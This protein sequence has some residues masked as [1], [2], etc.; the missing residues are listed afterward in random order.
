[1]QPIQNLRYVKH[2][3]I[4]LDKW[5]SV[6]CK[7]DNTLIYA[8]SYYLDIVSESWDAY[9]FG[10]YS[11]VMP[12]PIR[13]K[14]GITLLTQPAYCQQLGIF[15]KP[16]INIL[17]YFLDAI[18]TKFKFISLNFNSCNAILDILDNNIQVCNNYLL[19]LDANY[20]N[21]ALSYSSHT[22]R[23]L[24]KVQK[25]NLTFINSVTINDYLRFKIENQGPEVYGKNLKFLEKLLLALKER[26]II[27][28][29][30]VYNDSNELCSAGVFV[31][32][33]NRILYLNGVS[34]DSG[35]KLNAMYFLMDKVIAIYAES[36]FVIDFEGSK[37]SGIARFFRGFGSEP[38]VYYNYRYNKLPMPLRWLKK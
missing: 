34:N 33:G 16:P 13:K 21:L 25:N 7:S 8:Y 3:D 20:L 17:K 22:L 30:G 26:N 29:Y 35:K 1:M 23:H 36:S 28:I 18:K 4:D 15:P 11:Y 12:L 38:E 31:S 32:S 19:K 14:M 10:D 5:D 37:I 9:I 24:K 27:N 6:I 2:C